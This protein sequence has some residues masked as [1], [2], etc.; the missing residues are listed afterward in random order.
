MNSFSLFQKMHLS[1]KRK[2]FSSYV[3]IYRPPSGS[4]YE[5]TSR[6]PQASPGKSVIFPPVPAQVYGYG[7]WQ[8]W[9]SSCVGDSSDCNRL[10]LDSC[11]SC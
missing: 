1:F 11:T 10:K 5:V 2:M 9:I 8:L 6:V 3:T 4:G 7:P